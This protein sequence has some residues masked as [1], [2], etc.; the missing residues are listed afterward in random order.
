MGVNR[1]AREFQ[2]AVH[3][4]PFPLHPHT[5]P[6]GLELRELFAGHP[7]DVDA[8]MS[9]LKH[10]AAKLGLPLG[11]RT[12]TYNSRLAQELGK[13]AEKEGAGDFYRNAVYRAYFV[14][15]RNIARS[16]ELIRIAEEA[17][18]DLDEARGIIETRSFGEA[19]DA[20]WAQARSARVPAVPTH[21]FRGR[22]QVGFR[23]YEAL[24]EFVVRAGGDRLSG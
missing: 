12:R 23:P 1:I 22:A 15:G 19:V 21:M 9:R 13:W 6:E 16:D 20:D 17:G 4:I 3:W 10:V 14:Q 2:V 11:E 18:L 7:V 5:P 8:M 24:A